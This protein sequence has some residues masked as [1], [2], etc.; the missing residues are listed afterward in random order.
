MS[1]K[2][3]ATKR[4]PA[5]P[6]LVTDDEKPAR[7]RRTTAQILADLDRER[8][9]IVERA[10]LSAARDTT[11]GKVLIAAHRALT[12][13]CQA[14]RSELGEGDVWGHIAG[15]HNA[16]EDSM[17]LA[18]VPIPRIRNKEEGAEEDADEPPI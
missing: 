12:R 16:L 11:L 10:E 9:K 4:K 15:G 2:K 5:A 17:R 8:E 1:K 18:K 7:V 13:A 6:S 3:K 14:V